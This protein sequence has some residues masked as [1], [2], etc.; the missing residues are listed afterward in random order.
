MSKILI[1]Y[2]REDSAHV[3]GRIYDRLTQQFGRTAVFKDVDNIPLGIDFRIYLDQEVAKCDVFLAVIGRHWMKPQGQKGKSRL[4]DPADFVRLEIEAALKRQIPVIP[5]L[6]E[7]AVI[8]PADRLPT[9]LQ[10][11]SYRN[12]I[13]VRP[14]P[15]FHRDMDRLIE[16]LQVQIER[17][18][19]GLLSLDEPHSVSDVSSTT[20]MPRSEVQLTGQ[21]I[22]TELPPASLESQPEVARSH[23][24]APV[25]SST[26]YSTVG[27]GGALAEED[28]SNVEPPGQETVEALQLPPGLESQPEVT[29]S[30]EYAPVAFSDAHSTVG[31]G[32]TTAGAARPE[33]EGRGP[34]SVEFTIPPPG[35]DSLQ[36]EMEPFEEEPIAAPSTVRVTTGQSQSYLFGVIGLLVLIG[37]VAAFLTLQPKSSPIYSPPV[38]E[39]KEERQAEVIPPPAHPRSTEPVVSPKKQENPVERPVSARQPSVL[40]PQMIEISPGSFMMGG[41]GMYDRYHKVQLTKPFA[42]SRYELTFDEYD[43]FAQATGHKLPHDKGWGR[44]ALPVINVSWDD[45]KAYA[46]WLSQQIG[47]RYR[48]PTEAEWEYAARSGGKDETWAGISNESQLMDYAVYRE[49]R[50][51]PVGSKKPN[52][53]GLYD[54]SGNVY[55]WV[56]DCWHNDYNS[57]PADGLAWLSI[58][59]GDCGHRVVRGG[60]WHNNYT[61]ELRTVYRN[62]DTPDSRHDVVGFRLAQDLP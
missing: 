14:D 45:A 36:R 12:G 6:V 16:H 60:S 61:W 47:K 51:E 40:T 39:K 17:E 54:M 31:D 15:D 53:F 32:R 22:R 38:V 62:R 2:R 13:I 35:R 20:M 9:S 37:A 7:G 27:D 57:A 55:E 30:Q 5:V 23:E 59:N 58:N 44:G 18:Q 19:E 25:V 28:H 33:V 50:T 11:L 48:L 56:E 26:A 43:R 49:E 3:T 41:G 34:E 21:E 8:P 1:S 29:Q 46:Q 42:M 10:G 52:G 24:N 4:A